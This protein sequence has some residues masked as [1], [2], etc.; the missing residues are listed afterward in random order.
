MNHYSPSRECFSQKSRVIFSN[1]KA[2][3]FIK[4][5]EYSDK[6]KV[7]LTYYSNVHFS[8]SLELKRKGRELEREKRDKERGER[9]R[10]GGRRA[11]EGGEN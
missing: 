1:A 3:T 4:T 9:A 2:T 6:K 11:R 5:L 8:S 7:T 10:K